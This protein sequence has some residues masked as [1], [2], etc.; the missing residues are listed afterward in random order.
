MVAPVRGAMAIAMCVL[1]DGGSH[2]SSDGGG[3][4]RPVR[5]RWSHEEQRWRQCEA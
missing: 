1:C 2:T 3:R 5:R 4:A